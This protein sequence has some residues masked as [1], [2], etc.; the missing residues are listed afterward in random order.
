MKEPFLRCPMCSNTLE[1][2]E[3]ET[4]EQIIMKNIDNDTSRFAYKADA[5]GSWM[6]RGFDLSRE[7]H[8][9]FCKCCGYLH[10]GLSNA[11]KVFK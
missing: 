10:D 6:E 8:R 3:T 5:F 11:Y 1:V 4:V 2:I 7:Y 9:C